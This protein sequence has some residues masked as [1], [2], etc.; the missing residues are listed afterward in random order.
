MTRRLCDICG[1]EFPEEQ[2]ARFVFSLDMRKL[3]VTVSFPQ[4]DDGED[5]CRP[6]AKQAL[7]QASFFEED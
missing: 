4:E 3:R 2:E 6:C 7:E 1:E 5:I